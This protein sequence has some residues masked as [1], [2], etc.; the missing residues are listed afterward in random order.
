[1]IV[2]AE[3]LIWMKHVVSDGSNKVAKLFMDME[4]IVYQKVSLKMIRL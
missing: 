1:M 3:E 4:S 2:L